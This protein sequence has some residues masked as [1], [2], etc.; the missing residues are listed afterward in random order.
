MQAGIQTDRQ[1]EAAEQICNVMYYL[2]T[3]NGVL[4]GGSGLQ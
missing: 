2:L 4:P 1:E 3:A